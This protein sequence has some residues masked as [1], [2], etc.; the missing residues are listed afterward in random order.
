M[1]YFALRLCALLALA[2]LVSAA[3]AQSKVGYI[4]LQQLISVMPESSSASAQVESL[5]QSL[6]NQIT[7][8]SNQL[9]S[10]TAALQEDKS[11]LD[12]ASHVAKETE[13]KALTKQLE[14][15]QASAQQAIQAKVNELTLAVN[16][17]AKT[18][19]AQAAAEGGYTLVLKVSQSDVIFS[20]AQENLL[21]AAKAK[22]GIQ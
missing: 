15:M 22:L 5:R 16:E 8:L 21:P 9:E 20:A 18:A 11:P 17:K 2:C 7:T 19:V 13:V 14:D 12:D 3:R 10:K 1:K 6:N 4:D